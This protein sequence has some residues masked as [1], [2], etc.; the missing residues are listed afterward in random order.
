MEEDP[1]MPQ[2][3]TISLEGR[4][5]L[6]TGGGT[7]IGKACAGAMARLGAVVTI[8]GPDVAVLE[9]AAEDLRSDGAV[10]FVRADV[11]EEDQVAAAV[12]AA[13][14]AGGGRLDIALA[15]A[16]TGFPGSLL[17]L[18]K[19]HW[20]VPVGVNVLGTAFTIKHAAKKMSSAGGSIIT[21]SSGASSRLTKF[22]MT[23]SVTKAAVDELTRAAA[24]ELGPFGIRVN[25]VRPGWIETQ[26]LAAAATESN[27]SHA[28]AQT[29][30]GR[31][32]EVDDIARAVIYLASDQSEWVT[33]QIL[34]VCGGFNLIPPSMDLEGSARA[35]FPDGMARDFGSL[36]GPDAGTLP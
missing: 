9:Q 32:G 5:A 35:L 23:Y 17:H 19:E 20:M 25:C 27:R 24:Q 10:A 1:E 14:A 28:L 3:L 15:N 18:S 8:A 11:T 34:N 29:P 21:V 6:V 22:M 31:L 7:G 2:P 12:D 13:A 33:G 36:P 16:G 26:A 30:L 4:T